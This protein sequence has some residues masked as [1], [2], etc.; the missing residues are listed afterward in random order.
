MPTIYV[1]FRLHFDRQSLDHGDGIDRAVDVRN[2]CKA[3]PA[4]CT[5][6]RRLLP[7]HWHL[8]PA[9]RRRRKVLPMSPVRCVTHVSGRSHRPVRW[10]Y[11]TGPILL[12]SATWAAPEGDSK[13]RAQRQTKSGGLVGSVLPSS[14]SLPPSRCRVS[15]RRSGP[16]SV[17]GSGYVVPVGSQQSFQGG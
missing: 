14:A 9:G 5:S 12:L 3:D 1:R 4:A 6:V 15:L 11:K 17:H 2:L 8:P 7:G 10:Q 13:R 16:A